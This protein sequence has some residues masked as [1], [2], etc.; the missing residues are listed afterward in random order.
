MGR[1]STKLFETNDLVNLRLT[2]P[3]EDVLKV[4]NAKK[5]QQIDVSDYLADCVRYREGIPLD[6]SPSPEITVQAAAPALEDVAEAV[7][8]M[9]KNQGLVFSATKASESSSDEAEP[10]QQEDNNEPDEETKR[11]MAEAIRRASSWGDDDD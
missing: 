9:L 1:R 3:R 11:Q 10:I 8:N 6:G 7:I 2:K 5:M 4:L